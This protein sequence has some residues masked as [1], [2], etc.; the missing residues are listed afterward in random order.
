LFEPQAAF[1][2]LAGDLGG[3]E[4]GAGGLAECQRLYPDRRARTRQRD[5][6]GGGETAA[7]SSEKYSGYE[8]PH[9]PG[10]GHDCGIYAGLFP[11]TRPLRRPVR[12]LT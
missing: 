10:V 7:E 8:C 11:I 2:R 9:R 5:I 6:L 12:P 3:I 4:I 1:G